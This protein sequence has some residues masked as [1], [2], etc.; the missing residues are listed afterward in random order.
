MKPEESAKFIDVEKV[1]RDKNPRLLKLLPG[2]ILGYFRRILHEKEIN[3][4]IIRNRHH[5]GLSFVNA[6]LDEFGAKV[7]AIGEE[8]IPAEEGVIFA[9]NHPLG[10]LDAMAL[11]DVIGRKRKDIKF[12][13]NDVLLNLENLR[14]LFVPV[15]KHGRNSAESLQMLE[16][17]YASGECALVFPAGLVSRKNPGAPIRDLEWKKSFITKAKKY[18]KKI[19]PVYIEGRNSAFFYGLAYWRKLMGIKANIE[20]FYLVDEMYKQYNKTITVIFGE[21][22]PP[23]TFD[24]GRSDGRWAAL[25]KDHV[26]EMGRL[27]KPLSFKNVH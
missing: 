11:M 27:R 23:E 25:V 15:N 6:I 19:I 14:T 9:S 8:N 20:M 4:F 26:Y 1:I 22:I 16:Q 24:P 10:G 7:K 5:H 13:V 18:R 17:T 21:P 3:D 12:L 2:F